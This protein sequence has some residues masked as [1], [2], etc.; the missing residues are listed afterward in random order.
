MAKAPTP[1]KLE[2]SP[3]KNPEIISLQNQIAE[4]QNEAR[5]IARVLT[6]TEA[7]HQDA[8]NSRNLAADRVASLRSIV[9]EVVALKAIGRANTDDLARETASENELLAAEKT[10]AALNG[11]LAAIE[12]K[13]QAIQRLLDAENATLDRLKEQLPILFDTHYKKLAIVKLNEL[14]TLGKSVADCIAT[15]KAINTVA[16]LELFYQNAHF[17]MPSITQYQK[18]DWLGDLQ[19]QFEVLPYFKET[20]SD[21]RFNSEKNIE[22]LIQEKIEEIL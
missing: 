17:E 8:L 11:E 16:D 20:G 13:R 19:A 2:L 18:I 4:T 5:K 9:S 14:L 1:E 15:L 10:L 6:E 7:T 21:N 3:A 12:T 22:A